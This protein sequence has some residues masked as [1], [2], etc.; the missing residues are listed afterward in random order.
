MMVNS[1]RSIGLGVV[2]VIAVV[3]P[4]QAQVEARSPVSNIATAESL[5]IAPETIPPTAIEPAMEQVTSVSQLQDVRPSDWAYQALQTL[6]E[7]YGCIE[8]YPDGMFRGNRSLTRYEFAAGLSRCLDRINEQLAAIR[9]DAALKSD[10]EVVRKL[11][12]DFGAE[13]AT[14]RGTVDRLEAK[15]V[16]LEKQ[17]FS[18][19]TK[20]SGEVIAAVSQE[21]NRPGNQVVLQNRVRLDLDTSFTGKDVLKIRVASG[22]AR[23]FDTAGL[24]ANGDSDGLQTVNFAGSPNFDQQLRVD[25]IAYHTSLNE[26][27]SGMVA[28][29]NGRHY[30]Y[31]PT[32]NPAL[33]S[34]DGG[35]TT[36]S[37][38]GQRNP[39][40][41]IGGGSGLGMNGSLGRDFQ[42]TAGYLA[43]TAAN[44]TAGNGLFNGDRSL[45]AQVSYAPP[46]SPFQ[47]AL[48]Y[49]NAYKKTGAI[50]D[51][52]EGILGAIGTTIANNALGVG[53]GNAIVN[54]YGISAA[55]KFSPN[56]VLNAFGTYATADFRIPGGSEAATIATYGVGAAFPD[57]GKRGNLLGFVVGVTPYATNA[58]RS[59]GGGVSA[60]PW[61]VEGFY[62]Y[63][64]TDRL[65]ITPGVIWVSN[66]GQIDGNP[67]A[68]IG[69]VRATFSF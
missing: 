7:R 60:A 54:A 64:V 16:T 28:A 33:D 56:F 45:L 29:W 24:N 31:A 66:P 55:Y 2:G 69:T 23:P 12:E 40:Y 22:N 61:H 48:T 38:F 47:V 49:V 67:S 37:M 51:G 46:Q 32:M 4:A 57:F 20:L 27:L 59:F 17:Q 15:T 26:N 6:V 63:A 50:F 13:L 42:V 10:V 30:D 8:G 25:T 21:F 9:Q 5:S 19:T 52:G 36:L 1:V 3:T 62:K 18:T 39:I 11:Q 53:D 14:L 34:G 68:V 41:S 65:S 58:N 43:K 35:T 44:P